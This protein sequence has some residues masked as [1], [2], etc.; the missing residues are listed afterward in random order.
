MANVENGLED[1]LILIER[2]LELI[3]STGQAQDV[4]AHLDLAAH[5]LREHLSC[6]QQA[7]SRPSL[8]LVGT[9]RC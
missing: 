3:D 4:G 1:A 9:G 8:S 5:R 7:S 6:A 2:A